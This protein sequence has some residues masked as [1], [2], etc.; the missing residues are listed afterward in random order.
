MDR[1]MYYLVLVVAVLFGFN[2][3]ILEWKK[4]QFEKKEVVAEYCSKESR[5]TQDSG[6]RLNLPDITKRDFNM[7]DEK[8]TDFFK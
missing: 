5:S 3:A 8:C 1:N 6:G 4:F 2:F 7:I